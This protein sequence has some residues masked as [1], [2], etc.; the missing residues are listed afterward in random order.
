MVLVVVVYDDDD[1]CVIDISVWCSCMVT[2]FRFSLQSLQQ[3][4]FCYYWL[5]C[6]YFQYCI[7][8]CSFCSSYQ[9]NDDI[10]VFIVLIYFSFFV[11]DVL[12]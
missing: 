10:V 1:G 12:N 11:Y 5:L 7:S 8:F 6:C 9:R 4:C 3:S 2:A